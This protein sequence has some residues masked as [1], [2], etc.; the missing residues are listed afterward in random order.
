MAVIPLNQM[1]E[2]ENG[3][4]VEIQG[5]F[6]FVRRMESMN[7]R[8]GKQVTKLSTIFRRG[9]ITIRLDNTQ[10]ALGFG[11]ANKIFVEVQDR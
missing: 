2:G 10:V 8:A 5:G 4:I 1:K 9:P 6:G 3:I 11:M 7:I